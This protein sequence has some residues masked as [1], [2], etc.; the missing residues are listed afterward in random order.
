MEGRRSPQT[1]HLHSARPR[2]PCARSLRG[3]MAP[4]GSPTARPHCP[5]TPPH[6]ATRAPSLV[7][8]RPPPGRPQPGRAPAAG[9]RPRRPPGPRS[10]HTR[11]PRSQHARAPRG[12]AAALTPAHA[13]LALLCKRGLGS[14][15]GRT[16]MGEAGEPVAG[17]RGTWAAAHRGA[18]E[19][20]PGIL[21][22]RP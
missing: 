18:T 19:G 7:R 6:P 21:R 10:R 16:R 2:P 12:R 14:P 1:T 8:R 13:Q 5:G 22:R 15:G 3:P 17:E 9:T 20:L 11:C 4:L